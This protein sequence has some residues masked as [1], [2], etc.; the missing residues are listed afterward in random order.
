MAG[1][2]HEVSSSED[3]QRA[4][5]D[6]VIFSM[7]VKALYPSLDLE[8]TTEAVMTIVKKTELS[9]EDI[10]ILHLVTYLAVV[11]SRKKGESSITCREGLF[12]RKGD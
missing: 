5:L 10:Y 2:L 12:S 9:L 4:I 3:M 7:D 8:D 1:H 11:L 6:A